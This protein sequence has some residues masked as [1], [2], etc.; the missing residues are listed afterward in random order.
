MSSRFASVLP[1]RTFCV[2]TLLGLVTA[3]C[4]AG[5]QAAVNLPDAPGMTVA[6][7]STSL[8]NGPQEPRQ[9]QKP[10]D[11][12]QTTAGG[13]TN[14]PPPA[15]EGVQTKRIL[16]II[17]NFRAVNADVKLP[18]QSVKDKFT[19]ATEES[20]DYSALAIPAVV[21]LESWE[22]NATPEFGT[23]GVGYGRYLWHSVV[24][25]TSEN[26]FVQFI[27]PVI[28]HE[29]TRYYTLGHGGFTKRAGY[30]LSRILITRSDSAKKTF[31]FS[32]VLGAGASAGLSN[33]YYPSPERGLSNTAQNWGLDLGI[34]AVSFMFREFWPD[35]SGSMSRH[36][37]H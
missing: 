24:D 20:F 32:E 13:P 33:A 19:T 30:S 6:S 4:A 26:Y 15:G 37:S 12:A 10:A 7:S 14:I 8:S 23:D 31:N 29:D 1:V 2:F 35:I 25:Q 27:V 17:P 28:T 36:H 18:A 22:R 11:P 9:E 21:A 16:G 3:A 5:Q 34:D